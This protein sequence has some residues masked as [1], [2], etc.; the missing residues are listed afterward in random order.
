MRV[1]WL[2]PYL[3]FPEN[4]GGRIRVARLAQGLAERAELSLFSCLSQHDSPGSVPPVADFA[5]WSHVFTAGRVESLTP[6][7]LKPDPARRLPRELSRALAEADARA[8]FDAV[9][10]EH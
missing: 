10:V 6:F 7:S 8:P 9:V 5:P 1:A 3:P 4:T 2:T